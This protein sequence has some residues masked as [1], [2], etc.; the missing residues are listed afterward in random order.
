MN[1]RKGRKGSPNYTR[2][3]VKAIHKKGTKKRDTN[4]A[5]SAASQPILESLIG[6]AR[7]LSASTLVVV[8]HGE[9][10]DVWVAP[11]FSCHQY[12]TYIALVRQDGCWNSEKKKP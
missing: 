2:V 7:S 11:R 10:V 9:G 12:V 6:A 8:S 3:G 4:S 5:T 1:G